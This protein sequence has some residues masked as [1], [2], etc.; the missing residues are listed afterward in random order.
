M[1]MPATRTDWTVEML[2]ALEDDGQRY[3]LID[4]EL[5]V[6]PSPSDAHQLVAGEFAFQLRRYLGGT[7]FGRVVTAPID[8][9]RGDRTRNRVQPDV[10]VLRLR[11]GL[12]PAYPYE[13]RDLALIIEVS[14]P[15]SVRLDYE[16]KR[17]LYIREGVGEYWVVEPL[18][19]HVTRWRSGDSSGELLVDTI[20]WTM[21][22]LSMPMTVSLPHLF[23]DALD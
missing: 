5:F 1:F 19:R 3:E 22:G 21:P 4:G 11:D 23:A 15:G 7:R 20:T 14:S 6:T 18:A 16:I 9:R 10:L 2:D 13:L 17:E 8:V 12:R